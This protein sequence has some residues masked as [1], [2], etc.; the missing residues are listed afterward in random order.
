MRHNFKK[1]KIWELSMDFV[2][3]IYEFCASLPDSEKFG[4]RSQLTRCSV[5]IPSNIAEGSAKK[6]SA[7]F[8]RFLAISLGSAYEAETQLLICQRRNLGNEALST[9]ALNCVIPLQKSILSFQHYLRQQSDQ[10]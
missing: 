3:T 1:L 6:S 2:D 7:D 5:S 9:E 8:L 10:R 4:L